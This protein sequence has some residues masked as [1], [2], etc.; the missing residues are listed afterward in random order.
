MDLSTYSALRL[1]ARSPT[2]PIRTGIPV[3]GQDTVDINDLVVLG[4][5]V[6]YEMEDGRKTVCVAGY[7]DRLG[8]IRV[9]PAR[10]DSPVKWRNRLAIPLARNP[11]DTRKE[12]WKIRGSRA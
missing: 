11:T 9:Y 5:A 12:S 1:R 7:S 4:N 8:L 3:G 6:P 10:P 2:N